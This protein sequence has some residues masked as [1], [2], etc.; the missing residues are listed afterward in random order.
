MVYINNPINIYFDWINNYYKIIL[1]LVQTQKHFNFICDIIIL[2]IF[3]Q[4]HE[5]ASYITTNIG[6]TV[7]FIRNDHGLTIKIVCKIYYIKID[8]RKN[9]GMI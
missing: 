7:H 5:V 8:S 3:I 2:D 1:L 9:Y 4:G 6:I